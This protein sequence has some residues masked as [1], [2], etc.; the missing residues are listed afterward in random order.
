MQRGISQG[1][2]RTWIFAGAWCACEGQI[3]CV[4]C[5]RELLLQHRRQKRVGC[6]IKIAA[7]AAAQQSTQNVKD[8]HAKEALD[9]EELAVVVHVHGVHV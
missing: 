1:T 8:Q 9:P 4:A 5:S 2:M 7:P 3:R 6:F